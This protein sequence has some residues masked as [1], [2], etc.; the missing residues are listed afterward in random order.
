MGGLKSFHDRLKN[1]QPQGKRLIETMLALNVLFAEEEIRQNREDEASILTTVRCAVVKQLQDLKRIE[2]LA[3]L[4]HSQGNLILFPIRLALTGMFSKNN[5]PSAIT[6]YLLHGPGARHCPF[7]TVMVRV[8]PKGLPDDAKAVSISQLA[9]DSNRL[10]SEIVNSLQENGYL[11]FSEEVFS[12]LI[13]RLIVD[14]RQGKLRLPV[15]RERV[16]EIAAL[17]RPKSRIKIVRIE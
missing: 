3:S 6:D 7:G 5:R 16:A 1:L 10:E 4:G 8:G 11:I 13:D 2:T 15:S 9:R 12:S 14:V 17:N